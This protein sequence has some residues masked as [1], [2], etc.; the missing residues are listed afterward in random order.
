VRLRAFKLPSGFTSL[1]SALVLIWINIPW[2][3]L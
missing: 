2:R 3:D 1:L